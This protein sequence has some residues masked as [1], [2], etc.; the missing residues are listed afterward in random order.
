MKPDQFSAWKVAATPEKL[1]GKVTWSWQRCW[2]V[3]LIK[4]YIWI[5]A[6]FCR[7]AVFSALFQLTC[8]HSFKWHR[9]V[10]VPSRKELSRLRRALHVGA[11]SCDVCRLDTE[12]SY[13][14]WTST[15]RLRPLHC[16]CINLLLF[17]FHYLWNVL[18]TRLCVS[19]GCDT[20][21][22]FFF[23]TRVEVVRLIFLVVV[24]FV[25]VFFSHARLSY[26]LSLNLLPVRL[27]FFRH[28]CFS[29]T[30]TS[31]YQPVVSV[32]CL[33]LLFLKTNLDF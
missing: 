31:S 32:P 21:A 13:L 3:A 20:P 10:S 33:N 2:K 18:L 7:H 25:F 22:L 26:F 4:F 29:S 15:C 1:F 24:S 9:C 23:S 16:L 6:Y 12:A 28:E 27:A 30:L 5:L 8:E 17:P 11:A 19:A 14:L